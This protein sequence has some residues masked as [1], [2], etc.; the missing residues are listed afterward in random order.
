MEKQKVPRVRITRPA[1]RPFQLRYQQD[2]KQHR[3]S[4][5][6][7]DEAEALRLQS[8]LQAK[9]QLGLDV[10]PKKRIACGA[11]TRQ[12]TLNPRSSHK[13]WYI[14]WGKAWT[15][16]P[17]FTFSEVGHEGNLNSL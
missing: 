12:R 14:E 1:K 6:T 17:H 8:E 16:T 9:L 7:R 11:E 10:R 13:G 4:T 3:I 5:G 2:G 15:S